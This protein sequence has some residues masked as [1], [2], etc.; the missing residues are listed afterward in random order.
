MHVVLMLDNS[1][2]GLG[3]IRQGAGLFVE[4]LQGQ[5]E[6]AIMTLGASNQVLVDFSKPPVLYS[7]LQT[8][9]ARN[10]PPA[11][12]LDGLMDASRLLMKKESDRPVIV[13]VA[14]EVEELSTTRAEVVLDALQKSGA[15]FYYVGMGAPLT[16]GTRPALT[17][18]RADASTEDESTK[19]NAVI[20]AG[21]KNSGGRSEQVLN[22][23]RDGGLE[24]HRRR[25]LF[26]VPVT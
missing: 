15:R 7:A 6:F 19:R 8:L 14:S 17:D 5:A 26:Q 25:A 22:V 4:T 3:A 12:V 11:Y 23:G 20:G 10:S 24:G 16:R 1:G 13:L 21:P 9:L 2:L 18:N